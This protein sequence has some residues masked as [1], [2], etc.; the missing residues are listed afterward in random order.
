MQTRFALDAV[1]LA[2]RLAID[3][4]Q[5]GGQR[6]LD[7]DLKP[8]GRPYRMAAARTLE[9]QLVANALADA[10]GDWREVHL[11]HALLDTHAGGGCAIQRFEAVGA[12]SRQGRRRSNQQ[13][14]SSH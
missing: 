10:A 3:P 6:F 11:R 5:R 9:H 8:M 4:N 7:H 14:Q 12:A 13:T 1:N 2:E